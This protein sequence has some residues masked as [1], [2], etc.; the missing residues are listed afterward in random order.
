VEEWSG[1][2]CAAIATENESGYGSTRDYRTLKPAALGFFKN[3]GRLP[4]SFC[5][6]ARNLILAL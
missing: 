5:K 2:F 3:P 1:K 6:F 4:K